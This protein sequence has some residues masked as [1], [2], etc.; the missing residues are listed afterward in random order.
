MMAE[1]QHCSCGKVAQFMIR[2]IDKR[3]TEGKWI[4]VCGTSDSYIDIRNLVAL[5]HTQ[6]EAIE[7]NR[8]VK[9][10]AK[11]QD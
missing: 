7:I 2:K 3:T 11:K 5:G 6:K 9:R 8:E 4:P 10:L 1:I